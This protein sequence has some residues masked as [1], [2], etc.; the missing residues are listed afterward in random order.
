MQDIRKEA[1]HI[2]LLGKWGYDEVSRLV[3]IINE[4]DDKNH[5]VAND[6]GSALKELHKLQKRL[7]WYRRVTVQQASK[8]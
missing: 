4:L 8:F 6:L 3:E 5:K 1:N 2:M 7:D